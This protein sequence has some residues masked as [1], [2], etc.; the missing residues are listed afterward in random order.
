MLYINPYVLKCDDEVAYDPPGGEILVSMKMKKVTDRVIAELFLYLVPRERHT[1]MKREQWREW[2]IEIVIKKTQRRI[3]ERHK[4]WRGE[5]ISKSTQMGFLGS[6]PATLLKRSFF[7]DDV[8][9]V[10]GLM[11]YCAPRTFQD[12]ILHTNSSYRDVL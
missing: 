5:Y 11:W 8:S 6:E 9:H 4:G 1:D 2:N 7:V 12:F 10:C 3:T